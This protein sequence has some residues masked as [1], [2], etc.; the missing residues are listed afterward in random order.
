[1]YTAEKMLITWE[2]AARGRAAREKPAD[3]YFF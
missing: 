3:L 2:K 1:M